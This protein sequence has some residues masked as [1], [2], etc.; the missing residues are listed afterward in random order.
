MV[1]ILL[2][3]PARSSQKP[4]QTGDD[5]ADPAALSLFTPATQQAATIGGKGTGLSRSQTVANT[6]QASGLGTSMNSPSSNWKEIWRYY[7][8]DLKGLPYEYVDFQFITKPG[9]GENVLQRDPSS[10][11]VLE[12]A[13]GAAPKS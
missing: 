7:R 13:K 8:K 4:L 1:F 9:Y 2:G 11:D 5:T 6:E 12:R 10:L 3:P